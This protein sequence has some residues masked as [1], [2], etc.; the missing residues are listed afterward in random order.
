MTPP[1]DLA[2]RTA[3]PDDA[4]ALTELALRSKASWG[5]DA[6]FMAACTEELTIPPGR[7]GPRLVVAERAGVLVGYA[8]LAGD[9]PAVELLGLFVEP[10][11]QGGGIGRV[12]FDDAVQRARALGATTLFWD[13]DPYAEEIYARLGGRTVGS[14]PS[15]CV[16][17][18]MLPRMELALT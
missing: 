2:L 11:A 4:A 6:A 13:A 5:Y 17:G 18:R 10:A 12:L 15:G 7:C 8:E 16:P 9:P 3:R 14:E 1:G